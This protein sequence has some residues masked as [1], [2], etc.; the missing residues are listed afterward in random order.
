MSAFLLDFLNFLDSI[1]FCF[2]KVSGFYFFDFLNLLDLN[3]LNFLDSI[4]LEFMFFWIQFF[5][6]FLVFLNFD[7]S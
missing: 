3:F 6:D 5:F 7:F 2:S 4:F 1:F